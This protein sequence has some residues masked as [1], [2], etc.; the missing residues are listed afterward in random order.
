MK[1]QLKTLCYLL[2][3]SLPTLAANNDFE[4]QSNFEEENFT[5]LN[6]LEKF[7]QDNPGTDF[8]KIK[9]E[10]PELLQNL[11]LQTE[12]NIGVAKDM[13]I[14]GAFWWG[15]CLGVI[16]LLLVYIITDNDKMQMKSA[17]VGCVIVT[18]LV[19]IGGIINP[20]G[21]F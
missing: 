3:I 20:F 2:I 5:S 7:V 4:L 18:L 10:N 16:G 12:T 6:T 8:A 17:L 9:A 1:K 13:P 19:G 11:N 21:W 15:C 14:L